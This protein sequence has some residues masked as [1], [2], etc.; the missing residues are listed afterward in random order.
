MYSG[1]RR[2]EWENDNEITHSYAVDALNTGW[3]RKESEKT[4]HETLHI[5]SVAL[6][7]V[8]GNLENQ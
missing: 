2:S 5:D 6:V 3:S 7:I 1:W 8:Y 4:L